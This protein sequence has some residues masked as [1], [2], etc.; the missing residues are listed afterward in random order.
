MKYTAE[1][2]ADTVNKA[3]NDGTVKENMR[4]ASARIR[5]E[6]QMVKIAKRIA[7]FIDEF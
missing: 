4:K 3:L 5:S 6:N 2:M 1:Q 7:D